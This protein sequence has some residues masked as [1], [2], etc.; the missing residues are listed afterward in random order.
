M[1]VFISWSGD[2]SREVAEV[3][4]PW[5]RKLVQCTDTFVSLDTE[6]G[7]RW[8][9]EISGKLSSTNFGIVC[10]TPENLSAPWLLFEAGALSKLGASRVWTFLLGVSPADV[11]FPLAQFQHTEFSEPELR[12]LVRAV[13]AAAKRNDE[14]VPSEVDLE[15]LFD[16]L[17]DGFR[18]EIEAIAARPHEGGAPARDTNEILVEILDVVRALGR[19]P[20]MQY[21]EDPFPV[22]KS[23]PV[24]VRARGRFAKALSNLA[25]THNSTGGPVASP[26]IDDAPLNDALVE[27]FRDQIAR[28][29][30]ED[31]EVPG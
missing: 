30:E 12:K 4:A 14:P 11:K 16:A 8:Q 5:V 1:D 13:R 15:S 9:D 6:K 28:D 25:W 29:S 7:T 3:I 18:E 26:E 27:Y 20:Q 24:D 22:N 23:T 10:L 2:R 19:R 31:P 21:L 17:W